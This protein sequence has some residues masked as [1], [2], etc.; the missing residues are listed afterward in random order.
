MLSAV[1]PHD[2]AGHIDRCRAGQEQRGG[3]DLMWIGGMAAWTNPAASSSVASVGS[4]GAEAAVTLRLLLEDLL[5]LPADRR[6]E[7]DDQGDRRQH[8][9]RRADRPL[10]EDHG[11][12]ARQDHGAA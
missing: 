10:D 1:A 7:D 5:A 12:A 6:A 9:H 11:I 8:Q 2:R 4:I 3:N